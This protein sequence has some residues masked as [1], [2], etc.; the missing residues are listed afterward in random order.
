MGGLWDSAAFH[1]CNVQREARR[2]R[3][4]LSPESDRLFLELIV[5]E[6]IE[7]ALQFGCEVMDRRLTKDLD[8]VR[9]VV[10]LHPMNV[11]PT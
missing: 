7:V 3:I 4:H 8:P 10:G 6:A 1:L 11:S 2:Q 9:G 5:V